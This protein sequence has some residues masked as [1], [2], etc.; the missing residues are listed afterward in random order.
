MTVFLFSYIKCAILELTE[1]DNMRKS[2][3]FNEGI[4]TEIEYKGLE[5]LK[6]FTF[7]IHDNETGF[8]VMAVPKVLL[9]EAKNNDLTDY[10]CPIPCKYVT[11]KG[12]VIIDNH[13]IVDA[14]YDNCI[15][16]DIPENYY[17]VTTNAESISKIKYKKQYISL[18]GMCFT[19]I[20]EGTIEFDIVYFKPTKKEI[21]EIR[22]SKKVRLSVSIINDILFLAYKFGELPWMDSPFNKLLCSTSVFPYQPTEENKFCLHVSLVDA[23]D[24]H[25]VVDRTIALDTDFSISLKHLVDENRPPTSNF[26]A[27]V[28]EIQQNYN[29]KEIVARSKLNSIVK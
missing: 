3:P 2:L 1:E 29:T 16:I 15:G 11:E 25:I 9:N 8:I 20:K 17:E 13:V 4:V 23:T 26:K 21:E 14:P 19:E 22:S 28:A 24:G 12:F 10:E 18:D 5:S 6:E 7:F 27:L